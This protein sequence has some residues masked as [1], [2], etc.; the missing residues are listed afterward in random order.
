[1]DRI[2]GLLAKSG[3][4]NVEARAQEENDRN[5]NGVGSGGTDEWGNIMLPIVFRAAIG[6]AVLSGQVHQ[7]A[8]ARL[9]PIFHWL[10]LVLL[11]TFACFFT[12]KLI[13][14]KFPIEAQV[15]ERVGLFFTVMAFAIATSI[16][17]LS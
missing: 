15:L 12:S 8:Q 2:R 3:L 13:V 7:Q 10:S 16:I 17:F 4:P 1:M 9:H 6:L 14:S 5:N 11:L